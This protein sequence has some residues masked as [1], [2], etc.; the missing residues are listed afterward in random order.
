MLNHLSD[1]ERRAALS[2]V[3][4]G[5]LY[6]LGHL[7]DKN[8][9]VFPGRYFRQTLVT[10]AHHASSGKGG[11][12]DNDVNWVTEQVTGTMQLDSHLDALSHLQID[13]RRYNGW[14]VADLAGG[15]GVKRLGAETVPQ[16]VA[17][18]LLVDV[19]AGRGTERLGP[20]DR[21]RRLPP[22]RLRGSDGNRVRA[23]QRRE[24]R[25]DRGNGLTAEALACRP[26]SESGMRPPLLLRAGSRCRP[27][28]RSAFC[29][30]RDR[31]WFRHLDTRWRSGG[32]PMG[33]PLCGIEAWVAGRALMA[34]YRRWGPGRRGGRSPM[35]LQAL[36]L[37]GGATLREGSD[38]A[39][40]PV[41]QR[42]SAL[43]S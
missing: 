13:D 33:T 43:I 6:D 42:M 9:P 1:D 23:D 17:R 32:N 36:P 27:W 2:L 26:S 7:L 38:G 30:S 35:V 5:G 34:V 12:G 41:L 4:E 18:G 24:R 14:A 22:R 25:S 31:R 21:E 11:V 16:I 3:R 29:F 39:V 37:Y 8:V 20:G 10:T 15:S 28:R 19:P 40:V